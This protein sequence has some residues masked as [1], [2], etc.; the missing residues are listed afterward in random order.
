MG[1]ELRIL[2]SDGHQETANVA[3]GGRNIQIES[4]YRRGGTIRTV[5]HKCMP[6]TTCIHRVAN[7]RISDC[8]VR[9]CSLARDSWEVF[10]DVGRKK[11]T[12]PLP[13]RTVFGDKYIHFASNRG[14][15][16]S[17]ALPLLLDNIFIGSGF[18]TF[19]AI[20]PQ[21]DYAGKMKAW[22]SG[23]II[24]EKP[25][26]FFIDIGLSAGVVALISFL[27]FL[28]WHFKNSVVLIKRQFEKPLAQINFILLLGIIAYLA[29]GQ[30]ND[31]IVSVSIS[32]WVMLGL[33]F[34]INYQLRLET[35]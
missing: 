18:D 24:I 25:H 9:C 27:T 22:G 30:F 32:F 2:A 19:A 10:Y 35:K 1:A 5:H 13:I 7:C 28:G 20:F 34:N 14:Y 23:N 15:I 16:W 11:F 4:S 6:G 8:Y 3:L 12:E 26:N 33:M 31:S 17:R 21:H 29:S